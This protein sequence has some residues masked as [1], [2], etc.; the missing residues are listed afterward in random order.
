MST[1]IGDNDVLR[2]YLLGRLEPESGERVEQRLFSTDQ[3][4]WEHLCLEEEELIDAYVAGYLSDADRERF[5]NHFLSSD[6]RRG[7]LALAQALKAYADAR[8][9]SRQTGWRRLLRPVATPA[10]ALAAAA[11]LLLVV[12][13]GAAWRYGAVRDAG[14][15]VSVWV[16]AGL[17]RGATGA[18]ARVTIPAGCTLVHLQLDPG[19]DYE[20][21][22]ATLHDV[23]TGDEIWSQSRLVTSTIGNRVG[24][25]LTLPAELLPAGD[26]YLSLSGA[27]SPGGSPVRLHRYDF[28]VLR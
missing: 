9:S 24:L 23:T 16:S 19:G 10:W 25:S 20:S 5:E 28:R 1:H 15:D 6:E 26:Y 27:S 8:Q 17:V 7:K 12:L 4:F 2:R 14:S 11:A 18:V 22:Q 21:Y 3:I 13:P